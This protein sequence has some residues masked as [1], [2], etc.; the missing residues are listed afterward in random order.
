VVVGAY[1]GNP[2][3]SSIGLQGSLKSFESLATKEA[4]VGINATI[5]S[6]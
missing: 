2:Y 1:L 4:S 5:S 6:L 3:V